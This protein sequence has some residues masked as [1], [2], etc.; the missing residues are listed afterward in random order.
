MQAASFGATA[1]IPI[2]DFVVRP[3]IDF[4]IRPMIDFVEG[5]RLCR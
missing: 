4:V 5:A 3:M 1:T 2:I